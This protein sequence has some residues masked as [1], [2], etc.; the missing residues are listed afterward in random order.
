MTRRRAPSA[1]D[2]AAAAAAAES[3][4]VKEDHWRICIRKSFAAFRSRSSVHRAALPKY[5]R[6]REPGT[7]SSDSTY[8]E[9]FEKKNDVRKREST[10]NRVA[11]AMK[12]E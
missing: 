12:E 11:I 8:L 2:G 3:R 4:G 7:A 6:E 5:P 1:K 9:A 10:F